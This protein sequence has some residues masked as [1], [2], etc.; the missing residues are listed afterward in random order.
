MALVRGKR[1]AQERPQI[2]DLGKGGRDQPGMELWVAGARGDVVEPVPER[3]HAWHWHDDDAGRRILRQSPA[4][5]SWMLPG[6]VVGDQLMGRTEETSTT[7]T[8]YP[9]GLG[10]LPEWG[11]VCPSPSP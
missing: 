3:S 5:S 2:L 1:S 11:R 6:A 8:L 7:V 10:I 9:E 4:K